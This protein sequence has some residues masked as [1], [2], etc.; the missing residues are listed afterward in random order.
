[1]RRPQSYSSLSTYKKCPKLWHWCYVLGNRTPDSPSAK[2]GT[3]LHA[4]LEE[5]FKGGRYPTRNATLKPWQR[6]MENLTIFNPSPEAA[7]AVDKDW[8]PCGFDDPN[9]YARGK[10]DLKL[11][12]G[13][14]HRILDWKSGRVYPDHEGQGLM[15]MAMDE[16][17]TPLCQT[18]FVYL[19]IPL[20]TVPRTYNNGDR[21]I[22]IV[23]LM[24][25]ID[26]VNADTVYTAT[27][28]HEACRYCPISWRA[29][30]ECRSAP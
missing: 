2:R 8:K 6:F 16:Y 30:G 4:M 21:Q 15:Y 7:L 24:E 10:A 27:P 20:H 1:M 19:D 3:E 18:E 22:Q 23:K 14:T 12:V 9:A 29:G 28:S 5:F 13:N 26:I 11:T 25:Q 17:D